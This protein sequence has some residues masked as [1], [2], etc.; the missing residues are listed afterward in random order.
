MLWEA[1][2]GS[3]IGGLEQTGELIADLRR[4]SAADSG[5]PLFVSIDHEG[6]AVERLKPP[7]TALPSAMAVGATRS[8]EHVRAWARVI[9]AEI[10][11]LGI[12]VNYAPVLDV[13]SEPGNPVIGIRSFGESPALV[14]EMG[15][16]AIATLADHGIV[17]TAKHFPGHGAATV[18]SHL[19][20]PVIKRDRRQMETID[21]IPFQA[22]IDGGVETIM[23]AH[24][25]YP[26]LA[27]D[28]LPATMSHEVMT[29]LLRHRMGFRGLV[30]TD[31]L[32]MRA[33]AERYALGQAAVL[34]VQAGADI[35]LTL[36]T[37]EEQVDVFDELLRAVKRGEISTARVDESVARI[38][39]VKRRLML[40]TRRGELVG[41]DSAYWPPGL[42]ND[43]SGIE[44]RR[45]IAREIA[46]DAITVVKNDER[47]LPL[48]L[49]ENER[50]GLIEFA[51]ARFSPVEDG[52]CSDGA[53]ARLL[54]ERHIN[55]G[56]LCLDSSF[57][58]GWPALDSFVQDSDVLVVATRNALLVREQGALVE[59]VLNSG[60]PVVMV[61]LRNPHDIMMFPS[62]ASY[63]VSYGD[64]PASL[65]AV[66]ALLFGDR[67]PGGK[68]PVTIPGL[69]AYGHGL[70]GF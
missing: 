2:I 26:A 66:V 29:T 68:L 25:V 27:D 46:R 5:L 56:Y 1:N 11:A 65:E 8:I 32:V 70:D 54:T 48:R 12:N 50:L 67:Q 10:R 61:A 9:A 59:Q 35:V 43:G 51:G 58:D 3:G 34:S 14:A 60:K 20:L 22:A 42:E 64:S 33:I 13:N 4:L 55:T 18:D 45:N 41:P 52:A 6:G 15:S 44:E 21:L 16:A 24:A 38:L 19:D 17:T 63:V 40:D 53:L 62:A 36:T 31:A 39:A 47:L 7:A 37:L 30:I 28:H 69:F 49:L 57:R 23:S